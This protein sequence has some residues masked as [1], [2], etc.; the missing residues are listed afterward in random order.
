MIDC[1]ICGG[2]GDSGAPLEVTCDNCGGTGKLIECEDC[3]KL[4]SKYFDS[5]DNRVRC[6]SCATK[7]YIEMHWFPI[8]HYLIDMNNILHND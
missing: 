8:P 5:V 7:H 1:P 4:V 6:E 2:N 3:H